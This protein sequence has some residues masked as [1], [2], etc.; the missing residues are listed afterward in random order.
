MFLL[1]RE[2][3]AAIEAA[4]SGTVYREP[5]QRAGTPETYSPPRVYIGALP[6]KR[7]APGQGEDAPF[8]VIR[9]RAGE[10]TESNGVRAESVTVALLAVVYTAG[11]E[12]DGAEEIDSLLARLRLLLCE[13]RLWAGRW[14]REFPLRWEAGSPLPQDENQQ[15]HPYAQG[16]IDVTFSA[17]A[18]D[19][20]GQGEAL[21][22]I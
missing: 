8:V 18:A 10:I 5:Q 12:A 7:Q 13:R 22:L 9:P 3:K 19:D 16:K 2:L 6:P 11:G 1:L 15:P 21:D 20:A 17:P 4:F 14:E